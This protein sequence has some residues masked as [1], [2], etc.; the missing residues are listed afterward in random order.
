MKFPLYIYIYIYGSHIHTRTWF[1]LPN[2]SSWSTPVLDLSSLGQ[3]FQPSKSRPGIASAQGE[4]NGKLPIH[5]SA[6][7]VPSAELSFVSLVQQKRNSCSWEIS[8]TQTQNE[9]DEFKNVRYILSWVEGRL[10]IT[11]SWKHLNAL[12][13]HG[14]TRTRSMHSTRGQV[15]T[16]LQTPNGISA[17]LFWQELPYNSLNVCRQSQF[18]NLKSVVI[19]LMLQ[20]S[21]EKTSWNV[22]KALF[23]NGMTYQP[24]LQLVFSPDFWTIN[25]PSSKLLILLKKRHL[26]TSSWCDSDGNISIFFSRRN[27]AATALLV[28][29]VWN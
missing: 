8:W 4:W 27:I 9:M 5:W 24:Q 14:N 26:K 6:S 17:C 3:V 23:S 19:L 7:A 29:L 15:R 13:T 11:V 28:D 18:L 12:C 25:S 22:K 1:F 10:L 21:G 20:K 16:Q 2:S